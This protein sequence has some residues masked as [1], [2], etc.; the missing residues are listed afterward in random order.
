MP[1]HHELFDYRLTEECMT[2]VTISFTATVENAE[3]HNWV[4]LHVED[5]GQICTA[6]ESESSGSWVQAEAGLHS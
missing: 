1:T 6:E 5:N 2:V 3:E 4:L